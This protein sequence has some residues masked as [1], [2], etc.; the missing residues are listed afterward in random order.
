MALWP[1]NA[2][3]LELFVPHGIFCSGFSPVLF[4]IRCLAVVYFIFVSIRGFRPYGVLA[5]PWVN[6]FCG[7]L[8]SG[9]LEG[10]FDGINRMGVSSK[11]GSRQTEVP[12]HFGQAVQRLL[13]LFLPHGIFCSGFSPVL[14][15]VRCFGCRLVHF[16]IH[17]WIPAGWRPCLALS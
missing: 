1:S 2:A 9:G 14:F 10:F 13:E 11:M 7:K 3:L 6:C 12:W 16:V 5:W 4:P 8:S 15:P 17:P